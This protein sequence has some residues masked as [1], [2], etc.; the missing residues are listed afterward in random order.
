MARRSVAL[1]GR[2]LP[3]LLMATLL[4]VGAALLRFLVHIAYGESSTDWHF[5]CAFRGVLCLAEKIGAFG[6]GAY[7]LF[8]LTEN[9]MVCSGGTDL[10]FEW[11]G[12]A[13]LTRSAKS[14]TV[15]S[16][17]S[18]HLPSR[19]V[20]AVPSMTDF[21]GFLASSL[22]FTLSLARIEVFV[23]GQSTLCICK[24]FPCP[25]VPMAPPVENTWWT[26]KSIVLNSPTNV[27]SIAGQGGALTEREV[28]ISARFGAMEEATAQISS[29]LI[30]ADVV[31]HCSPELVRR[32]ERVTKKRPM[33]NF[34]LMLLLA[35]EVS[36]PDSGAARVSGDQ[37]RARDL[38]GHFAPRIGAGRLFIGFRT[39]QT[40]GFA[41]HLA[42]PFIPTVERESIDLVDP[43]LLQWNSELLH[44]SGT[45]MRLALEHR[46]SRIGTLY[47]KEAPGR[48][49]AE[50][51]RLERIA[52][53]VS[54]VAEGPRK[55]SSGSAA[56]A[57]A[58]TL[59]A[60]G[61]SV[62]RRRADGNDRGLSFF[63]GLASF[64][65]QAANEV[66]RIAVSVTDSINDDPRNLLSPPDPQPTPSSA[67]REA[68]GLMQCFVPQ[69]TT[70]DTRVGQCIGRGFESSLPNLSTPVL[71]CAGVVRG[72]A[73][74]TARFG[75]QGFFKLD[76]ER[77]SAAA[78]LI[79]SVVL[80]NACDYVE[81]VCGVPRGTLE[82]L[83]LHLK[84]RDLSEDETLLL[85]V[86]FTQYARRVP[87]DVGKVSLLKESVKVRFSGSTKAVPLREYKY[88][89]LQKDMR[90]VPLPYETLPTSFSTRLPE[91]ILRENILQAIFSPLPFSSWSTWIVDHE[92]LTAER[93]ESADA[94]RIAVFSCL[95]S[96]L[97]TI[98]DGD[99]PAWL[100]RSLGNRRCIPIVGGTLEKP[101]NS[102]L[103]VADLETFESQSQLPKV[104]ET[105]LT[106][107]HVTKQFFVAIGV[108]EAVSLDVLFSELD[109]LT[110]NQDPSSLVR[111]L[112]SVSGKLS[113][114]EI[115]RLRESKFLPSTADQS[116]HAP[117]G[118]ILPSFS[119]SI[120]HDFAAFVPFLGGWRETGLS[121]AD[122]RRFL[123]DTLGMSSKPSLE[124]IVK[125][126]ANT[127][128]SADM[129]KKCIWFAAS[130]LDVNVGGY[131]SYQ[132]L[133]CYRRSPHKLSSDAP[134]KGLCKTSECFTNQDCMQMGFWTIEPGLEVAAS[135][136]K[137]ARE[138][139]GQLYSRALLEL[140]QSLQGIAEISD[141]AKAA[142]AW[143]AFM[144][145]S[146]RLALFSES[147]KAAFY[148]TA[149]VPV[150][151]VR[152]TS[153]GAESRTL[154]WRRPGD[155]YFATEEDPAAL[156]SVTASLFD[157]VARND[158]LRYIGTKD[159]PSLSD[160]C[161]LIVSNP[162]SV[163]ERMHKNP[164]LYEELLY[165]IASQYTSLSTQV[166]GQLRRCPFLLATKLTLEDG[167]QELSAADADADTDDSVS[168]Q[169]V[170][171]TLACAADVYVVDDSF[172][173]RMFNPLC[174][175]VDC[176]GLEAFYVK[177]G[178]K[179]IS[180]AVSR[181]FQI[182]S[183]RGAAARESDL[184]LRL[185]KRIL[186]R[187]ALILETSHR[188]MARSAA[189]LLAHD[190]LRVRQV[191]AI[192]AVYTLGK[193]SR[194][195]AVSCCSKQH[196]VGK[197]PP[198][199]PPLPPKV[200][201]LL[202][203]T[204]E[205]DFFDVAHALGRQLYADQRCGLQDVFFLAQLLETT[206][207][208]LR[209]RGFPVDKVVKA[210]PLP[211][212]P[213]SSP[214]SAL[215]PE[216]SRSAA[217]SPVEPL[218]G[219]S[220]TS[221][222]GNVRSSPSSGYESIL[223]QMFP[224]AD[225]AWIRRKL[226]E[227]PGE[228]GLRHVKTLMQK[229]GYPQLP[230]PSP[231]APGPSVSPEPL[232]K[233]GGPKSALS[234]SL[235]KAFRRRASG[236]LP[237]LVS[238]SSGSSVNAG[239]DVRV[240]G[241]VGT[242]RPG[243]DDPQ[244]EPDDEKSRQG[245]RQVLTSAVR[246]SSQVPAA[247]VSSA[248]TQA[249]VPQ[250]QAAAPSCEAIPGHDLQPVSR[251]GIAR[252]KT[253]QGLRVFVSR[254]D[255]DVEASVHFCNDRWSMVERFGYL[256]HALAA[257]FQL[258]AT[259]MAIFYAKSGRVIAFNA[260][261]S[262]FF[263]LR[264]YATLHDADSRDKPSRE[265]LIFWYTTTCHELAHNLAKEH[266]QRHGQ[267][268]EAMVEEYFPRFLDWLRQL[269]L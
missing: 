116:L 102:Y 158:F 159:E 123:C 94:K 50:V 54:N 145:F 165:R 191:L 142:G 201:L 66:K 174:L 49:R 209:A 229:E 17:T 242:S 269:G 118:L 74:F 55:D 216:P 132:F 3:A 117:P 255:R 78:P 223:R 240:P 79:R 10:L 110:W 43:T 29:R 61:R 36:D 236:A 46:M 44:I 241:N 87:E 8:S 212:P 18:F 147:D 13:L 167:D 93:S 172:L 143:K 68:I 57:G 246:A 80:D 42:A 106:A 134:G 268:T 45:V 225:P 170:T 96:G 41:V 15:D 185:A 150:W 157:T 25:P 100:G 176:S 40:T 31:T 220:G 2:A 218:L 92:C 214:S 222:G 190:S 251:E 168:V 26:P 52:K 186:Q 71:S 22:T 235:V 95:A 247:G 228:S 88:F 9:P 77:S 192:T 76:E 38:L 194:S 231:P 230:S 217:A 146:P 81:H 215:P 85:L 188:S 262:L 33:K 151:A 127:K 62:G 72:A 233:G 243:N 226:E 180:A 213:R 181:R 139:N 183:D 169:K 156:T 162:N 53:S 204:G 193:Q 14:D 86:W 32:M 115:H 197:V 203:V 195:Q 256:L 266:N 202:F 16:W 104:S 249:A 245:V 58:S 177:L 149:I 69:R 173:Q 119:S 248:A 82:S 219:P 261:G 7:S 105:L 27:F 148:S 130:H 178:A 221:S 35:D 154:V 198:Y 60:A 28:L 187:R 63:S 179:F 47:A 125:V 98:R 114:S 131:A 70:P 113:R 227:N 253:A 237:G 199:V 265:A 108:R 20:Y 267:Y 67:E 206:L 112:C 163:Y 244:A 258:D 250:D 91:R 129:R 51:L 121:G 153:T 120:L 257:V 5:R 23:D 259:T 175:P 124:S 205:V 126:A 234:R 89:V 138:P 135:Q 152:R 208:Q 111:Y 166:F 239:K 133:P 136:F 260:S 107:P 155:V 224:N 263:N 56:G 137:V 1:I 39:S 101:T 99:Y 141:T 12:D 21:G 48:R 211:E 232:Q 37:R 90:K 252:A 254:L 122:E 144:F 30:A 34:Q 160:I 19:D 207:A 164:K 84:S 97:A 11:D 24:T 64:M 264:H 128:T 182:P 210:A 103:P 161:E 59:P 184:S 109:R 196:L 171:C 200:K 65:G 83:S 75:M 189:A 73:A 6:V 238:G 4:Q 140:I